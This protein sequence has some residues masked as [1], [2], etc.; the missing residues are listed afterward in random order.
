M[1]ISHVTWRRFVPSDFEVKRVSGEKG[2]KWSL[3]TTK[4]GLSSESFQDA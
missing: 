3:Y 2:V 1:I 4:S